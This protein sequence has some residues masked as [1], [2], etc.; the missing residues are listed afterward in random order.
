MKYIFFSLLFMIT[1]CTN[2]TM[3]NYQ[4]RN[5]QEYYN[6][7]GIVQYFLADLPSWANFSSE[8]R[9]HRESPVRYIHLESVRKSFSL[10]YEEAIQFQLMFNEVTTE[11]K[12][13]AQAKVIPFK[14]EEKIFFTVLDKIKAGIRNFVKPRYKVANI[15]WIDSAL[16]GKKEANKLKRIIRSDRFSSGHPVYL[17]LCMSRVEMRSYLSSKGVDITG[18]KFISYEMFNPYDKN[19]KLVAIPILELNELFSKKQKLNIFTH[20]DLPSEFRGKFKI[21]KF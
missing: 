6:G 20:K 2:P 16:I 15:L 21:R 3:K 7:I 8:G 18:A 19:G 13:K 9:C 10:N 5:T 17:S 11:R 12:E 1:S 4:R 14:D